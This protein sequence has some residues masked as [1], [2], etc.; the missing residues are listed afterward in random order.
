MKPLQTLP[1]ETGSAAPTVAG[2]LRTPTDDTLSI[3][4]SPVDAPGIG[5]SAGDLVGHPSQIE[6]RWL[7]R[8]HAL[9]A[10]LASAMTPDAVAVATADVCLSTLGARRSVLYKV[11]PA[12]ESI[13]LAA[14]RGYAEEMLRDRTRIPLD[15]PLPLTDAV[16]RN[17]TII[18]DSNVDLIERYPSAIVDPE[19]AAYATAP[20]VFRDEVTWVV[21]LTMLPDHVFTGDELAFLST[22]LRLCAAALERARL[23]AAE[24]QAW[25]VARAAERRQA[26]LAEASRVLSSSLDYRTTLDSVARSIVPD[27][28]DWCIVDM[29]NDAGTA[30]EGP[31]VAH[32]DPERVQWGLEMRARYPTELDEAVGVADVLR[33]G[34]SVLVPETTDEMLRLGA[35]DDEHWKLILAA[36]FYSVMIVPL[37]ARGRTLGTITFITSRKSQRRYGPDDLS[38]A[39]DLAQRAAV[40][41]DNARLYRKRAAA[42]DLHSAGERK[43]ALLAEASQQML[44]STRLEDLQPAILDLAQR[45]V[46][47]DA[48]ALWRRDPET[49]TWH[50]SA[51]TGLNE[52]EAI[53]EPHD[54]AGLDLSEPLIVA[55]VMDDPR[56]EF[57]R[58]ILVSEGIRALLVLPLVVDGQPSGTLALYHHD[59][60]TFAESE[61]RVA[62]ALASLVAAAISTT[63]LHEE[64]IKLRAMAEEEIAERRRVETALRASEARYRFLAE[65]MPQ[66]V[67]VSRP[68]GTLE[69]CNHRWFEY[70]GVSPDV[71]MSR[72]RWY[73]GIHPSDV[74]LCYLS[75]QKAVTSQQIWESEFRLRRADDSTYR[76]HLGRAIPVSDEDGNIQRW[77][78]TAVD[79][80]GRKRSEESQ[81]FLADLAGLTQA[82]AEPEE[83]LWQTVQ[84]LGR[85]MQVSRCLYAEIDGATDSVQVYRDFCRGTRS[86]A[87]AHRYSR[88]GGQVTRQMSEGRSVV[89]MDTRLDPRTSDEYVAVYGPLGI[90]ASIDVP[91]FKDGVQTAMLVVQQSDVA[92]YWTADE[93]ELVQAVAERIRLTVENLR[94]RRTADEV[95]ERQRVMLREMLSHVTDGKLHLCDGQVDLPDLLPAA[96]ERAEVSMETGTAPLRHSVRRVARNIGFT[97]DRVEELV[98]A[99]SEAAMNA[100]VHGGG[101]CS[102]LTHSDAAV[103]VRIDDNG[104][105]IAIENLSGATLRAGFTTAGTLGHG[106]KMMLQTADRIW[107]LTSP[108][109]TTV[110]IEVDRD[111]P[112]LPWI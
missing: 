109:G 52:A 104:P 22:S 30:L 38:L 12:S 20:L 44:A 83:I 26:F 49:S 9:T 61:V 24:Q 6:L 32:I 106:M 64:D 57:R 60:H 11:D 58:D 46:A 77:F 110:V 7:D 71:P 72:L 65:S 29:L 34:T 76:W 41:V 50:M 98:T 8:L 27:M 10:A 70:T 13:E 111:P 78:G 28:A 23:Y 87:G 81:R 80:D 31:V 88:F 94:L 47:A 86:M 5:P 96:D 74:N 79:I 36:G 97:A 1:D 35:Q 43:L 15:C 102:L 92:R 33:S 99:V 59:P 4:G 17:Q 108:T 39:E 93:V 40:A 37:N 51:S 56:I 95:R 2:G 25:K 107:L 112:P 89:L 55:D 69:Y 67:W 53:S 101:G 66:V 62:T 90:R 100:I 75:W 91:I 3:Q 42:L 85:H 16:R 84:A 45:L 103:Q 18:V 19:P 21:G 82:P 73:D 14:S 48:Y 63:E 105:G 54:G 68:D